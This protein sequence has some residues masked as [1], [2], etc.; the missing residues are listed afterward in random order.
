MSTEE[1][2]IE[3]LPLDVAQALEVERSR[4]DLPAI[5]QSRLVQRIEA[6]DEY[7]VATSSLKRGG[8]KE[9]S[10]REVLTAMRR[11]VGLALLAGGVLW[12]A[13][14]GAAAVAS[15][16]PASSARWDLKERD[17]LQAARAQLAKGFAAESLA[18]LE[19]HA[20]DFP[21]SVLA[22][23]RECAA[24]EALVA[25][26]QRE[27]AEARAA[28]FKRRFPGHPLTPVVDRVLQR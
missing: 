26:G 10:A 8:A 4:P 21:N 23:E 6:T 17:Q 25:M 15:M 28:E 20:R 13:A 2:S 7:V 14:M 3:P 18:S 5:S 12:G 27:S 22:D 1:P 24:I 11:P 16:Q 19:L 9:S